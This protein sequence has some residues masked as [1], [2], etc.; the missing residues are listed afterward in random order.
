M[1]PE[2]IK[3]FNPVNSSSVTIG[4]VVQVAKGWWLPKLKVEYGQLRPIQDGAVLP[5][6]DQAVKLLKQAYIRKVAFKKGW[7]EAETYWRTCAAESQ[8]LA[9]QMGNPSSL[10]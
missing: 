4:C 7:T 1:I 9:Q 10:F 5:T 8:A 3:W 2:I 6:K